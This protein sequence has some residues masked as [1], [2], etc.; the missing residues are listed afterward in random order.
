MTHKIAII[1]TKDFY[2]NYGDDRETI[3]RSITEWEEVSTEDFELLD[4][5]SY[6]LGFYLIEQ[7]LNT[8][9]FVAKTIAD[10]KALV[11]KEATKEAEEKLKR[12][13]KA[14]ERKFKKELKDKESK[15]A[16]LKKLQE[17]LGEAAK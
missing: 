4:K 15:I 16:L 9:E 12:E 7:P 1:T 5:A 3:I 13:E 14:R 6:K 8:K 2:Y 17:E 10:Y 11:K